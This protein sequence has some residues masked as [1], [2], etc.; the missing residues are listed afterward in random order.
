VLTVVLDTNI[1][2]S[3]LLVKHGVPAQIYRGMAGTPIPRSDFR[4][5]AW[6]GRPHTLLPTDPPAVL[7]YGCKRR[8]AARHSA[9]GRTHRPR[10]SRRHRRAAAR[11]RR[12]VPPHGCGRIERGHPGQQRSGSS[13]IATVWCYSH[14][15]SAHILGVSGAS[16]VGWGPCGESARCWRIPPAIRR[17]RQVRPP[18][19][20]ALP[21]TAHPWHHLPASIPR[22]PQPPTPGSAAT[23][24]PVLQTPSAQRDRRRLA[25]ERKPA[26]SVLRTFRRPGEIPSTGG[27]SWAGPGCH[28]SSSSPRSCWSQDG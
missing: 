18:G 4:R 15:E 5:T 23:A 21:G 6:R 3:T 17:G 12:C 13:R 11:S 14:D 1:Y 24:S 16:C 20:R 7:D 2:I 9:V 25:S 19:W 28:R 26:R 27:C 8:R 10:Y 22:A